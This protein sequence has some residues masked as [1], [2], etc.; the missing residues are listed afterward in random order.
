MTMKKKLLLIASV[1][2]FSIVGAAFMVGLTGCEGGECLVHGENCLSSYLETNYGTS[3]VPC[4]N[5]GDVCQNQFSYST[6]PTC[7]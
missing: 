2:L 1:G 4:C 3:S 6:V 7:N 5:A